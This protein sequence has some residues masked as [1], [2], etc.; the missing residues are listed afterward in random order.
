MKLV[1]YDKSKKELKF[2]IDEDKSSIYVNK[3]LKELL[4]EVVQFVGIEIIN[5][6]ISIFAKMEIEFKLPSGTGNPKTKKYFEKNRIG[7]GFV[8]TD[9]EETKKGIEDEIGENLVD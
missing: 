2:K 1:A 3:S 7:F 5:D 4:I 8:K 9:L 6:L